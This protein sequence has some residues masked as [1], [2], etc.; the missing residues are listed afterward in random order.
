MALS[1]EQIERYSRQIIVPAMGGI[2]QERLL[3]A[4]LVIAGELGDV[5]SVLAYLTGAGVGQISLILPGVDAAASTPMIARMRDLNGDVSVNV[6]TA[7]PADAN[8]L[9]AITG[10][11]S[12]LE[13][14]RTLCA[15]RS[16]APLIFARLDQPARI[17]LI[18]MNPPCLGCADGNLL[19][20]FSE[21]AGNAGM[22]AM[23]ATVEALKL[24]TGC[25]PSLKP[26]LIEFNGYQVSVGE[27]RRA[28]A[29]GCACSPGDRP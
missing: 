18:P 29:S 21:H 19:G 15:G 6:A 1:N 3:A 23:I 25:M 16:G 27:L 4:R 5:E 13:V 17:A 20:P 14:V 8:L 11:T 24:M 26:A 10:S 2:G 22:V 7:I 12:A 9:L 28:P